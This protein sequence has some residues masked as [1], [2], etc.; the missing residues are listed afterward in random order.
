MSNDK[1]C[2]PLG[3]SFVVC[4]NPESI[5]RSIDVIFKRL[6]R[7]LWSPFDRL[8]VDLLQRYGKQELFDLINNR[9]VSSILEEYRDLVEIPPVAEGEID[10]VKCQVFE[11]PNE[12][13]SGTG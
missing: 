5:T 4:D 9:S 2:E 8:T 11:N 10:G 3:S 13:Q 1:S 12:G 6:P 7:A